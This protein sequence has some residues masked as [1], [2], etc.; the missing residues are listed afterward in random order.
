MGKYQALCAPRR[1]HRRRVLDQHAR[2]LAPF[3]APS[4]LPPVFDHSLAPWSV[5]VAHFT[6]RAHRDALPRRHSDD[7][8]T[9]AG[10]PGSG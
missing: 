7:I 4:P 9:I 10:P 5:A 6:R 2:L 1:G 3:R 8:S